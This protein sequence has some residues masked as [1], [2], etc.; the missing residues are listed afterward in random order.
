MLG[1][2]LARRFPPTPSIGLN[3]GSLDTSFCPANLRIGPA[4]KH[5]EVAEY[6]ISCVGTHIRSRQGHPQ[7]TPSRPLPQIRLGSIELCKSSLSSGKRQDWSKFGDVPFSCQNGARMANGAHA[8]P[9]PCNFLRSLTVYN[10]YTCCAWLGL[11]MGPASG[12]K[13]CLAMFGGVQWWGRPAS[14]HKRTHN[15]TATQPRCLAQASAC[16][17]WCCVS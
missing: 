1:N 14:T 8:A 2:I 9:P 11:E 5:A 10:I 12:R 3:S 13:S 6:R 16:A 15:R 17:S 4:R 7:N